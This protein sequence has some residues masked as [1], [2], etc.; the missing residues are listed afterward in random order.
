M[1]QRLLFCKSNNQTL[2]GAI[3]KRSP[4]EI[5]NLTGR[6][7]ERLAISATPLLW[8]RITKNIRHALLCSLRQFIA[9]KWLRPEPVHDLFLS[10]PDLLYGRHNVTSR[11]ITS[12]PTLGQDY[13]I[14]A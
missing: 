10:L 1:Y 14:I 4:Q 5:S 13:I 2:E 8:L 7:G 11:V 6:H 12:S 9:R 3:A